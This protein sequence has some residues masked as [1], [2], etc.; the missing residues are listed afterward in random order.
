MKYPDERAFFLAEVTALAKSYGLDV[1]TT[2]ELPTRVRA[3]SRLSP[4]EAARLHRLRRRRR[5]GGPAMIAAIDIMTTEDH[6]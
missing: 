6:D 5:R 4:T 1:R 3:E 2:T